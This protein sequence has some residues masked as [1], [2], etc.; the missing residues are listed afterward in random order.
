MIIDFI[1][2]KCANDGTTKTVTVFAKED[3]TGGVE[4]IKFVIIDQPKTLQVTFAPNQGQPVTV[5]HTA[6]GTGE[7][8]VTAAGSQKTI[9]RI[10][11]VDKQPGDQ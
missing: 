7:V 10:L 4:T 2:L 5:T 6:S 1:T 11:D 3:A 8:V 9:K